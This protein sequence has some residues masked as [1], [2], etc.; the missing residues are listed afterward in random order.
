VESAS[1]V[2]QKPE[3]VRYILETVERM[4]EPFGLD[5]WQICVNA[6]EALPGDP[7]EEQTAA[8]SAAPEYKNAALAFD[9]S[10]FKTGDDI[11]EFVAHELAH[12]HTWP[13]HAEAEEN[14]TLVAEMS[15]EYMRDAIHKKL[16]EEARKAA[17]DTTTQVG[18]TYIRILRRLWAAEAT[19]KELTAENKRLKKELRPKQVEPKSDA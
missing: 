15:P 19:V 14:A 2:A 13:I 8:C 7:G 5:R 4:R 6:V 18:L 11:D 17:E 3:L 12:C 10:R 1:S 9:T 16:M